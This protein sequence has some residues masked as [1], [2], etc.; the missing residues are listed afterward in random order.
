MH[1][2][3]CLDLVV[4]CAWLRTRQEWNDKLEKS[5]LLLLRYEV[6]RCWSTISMLTT[7]WSGFLYRRLLH[8]AFC[9]LFVSCTPIPTTKRSWF[10]V[11]SRSKYN[12]WVVRCRHLEGSLFLLVSENAQVITSTGKS[13]SQSPIV[14]L[15]FTYCRGWL[16]S[17]LCR[18]LHILPFV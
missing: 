7:I 1:K 9:I 6:T 12:C 17:I 16:V 2:Q 3:L 14:R 18:H 11:T 10:L 5:D 13:R 4:S 8:Y 15:R